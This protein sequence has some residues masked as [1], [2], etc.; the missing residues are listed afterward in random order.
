MP[1]LAEQ[2]TNLFEPEPLEGI[3]GTFEG[4]TQKPVHGWYAYL[5]LGSV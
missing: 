2:Q 3:H 5:T 1:L 4:A